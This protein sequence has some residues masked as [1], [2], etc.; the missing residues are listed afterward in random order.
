MSWK[1]ALTEEIR[2]YWEDID[3]I[4]VDEEKVSNPQYEDLLKAGDWA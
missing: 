2:K 3:V 4:E 1:Q